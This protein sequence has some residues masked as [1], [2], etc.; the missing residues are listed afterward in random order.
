MCLKFYVYREFDNAKHGTVTGRPGILRPRLVVKSP[1]RFLLWMMHSIGGKN[2]LV[3]TQNKSEMKKH[4][5][6][7]NV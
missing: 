1:D 7:T 6:S 3:H 4:G 5:I 2:M